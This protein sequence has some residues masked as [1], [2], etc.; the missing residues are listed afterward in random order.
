MPGV[1]IRTGKTCKL[2]APFLIRPGW[3]IY[4]SCLLT[5]DT[6]SP[7]ACTPSSLTA[8]GYSSFCRY[9][10]CPSFSPKHIT[11]LFSLCCLF[12]FL[13]N[14][15]LHQTHLQTSYVKPVLKLGRAVTCLL[16]FNWKAPTQNSGCITDCPHCRTFNFCSIF[17]LLCL[18]AWNNNLLQLQQ[19]TQN[20]SFKTSFGI[21]AR[22]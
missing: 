14:F 3:V 2:W 12:S 22:T 1:K 9:S 18:Y 4:L 15:R 20:L 13:S 21:F 7:P 11:Q 6:I 19:A 8:V 17:T 10:Y 5:S 16:W